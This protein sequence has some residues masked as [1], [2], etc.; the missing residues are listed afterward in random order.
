MVIYFGF[1]LE[2]NVW[3]V[4]SLA[5]LAKSLLDDTHKFVSKLKHLLQIRA[6]IKN[7]FIY[8]KMISQ[9]IFFNV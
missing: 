6:I 7:N 9:K 1:A 3:Q 5:R 8:A 2:E 4:F